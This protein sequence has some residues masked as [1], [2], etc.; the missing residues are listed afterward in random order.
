LI[1]LIY[2][3]LKIGDLNY[4]ILLLISLDSDI[5][6]FIWIAFFI[7]FA[8]KVPML[9]FHIWL[10]EA[11]VEAPTIGSVI[12]ASIL[13]KLGI[14]GMLKFLLPIL[15]NATI[16]FSPL[17]FTISTIG[18]IYTSITAIRQTDIKRIIA[19]SSVAHMGIVV[20]GIFSLN[21]YGL[22][23]AILQSIS[24]GFIASGLFFAIG[25]LYERYRTRLVNYYGGIASVMP[26]FSFLF[27]FYTLANISLPGTSSFI[28]EIFIFIGGFKASTFTICLSAS[29]M[30]LG[31]AYSLWLT[32]KI[33]FGNIKTIYIFKFNDISFKDIIIH[34]PLIFGIL[35]I[36]LYPIYFLEYI[37]P[38]AQNIIDVVEIKTS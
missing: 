9:P 19:Y 25:F 30:V 17:I 31:G 37:H 26:L 12:L 16:Y 11:H 2:L 32:N 4:N 21:L 22:E 14:Y 29:S 35:F 36:G 5:E 27:L 18:V 3:N 28:G 34:T 38:F 24:H 10:P 33:C 7:A 15:P 6:K 8:V 13:L 1:S 20:I 23:G